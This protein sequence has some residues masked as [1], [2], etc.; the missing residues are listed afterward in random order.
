MNKKPLLFLGL[1]FA[2]IVLLAAGCT[3]TTPG[4]RQAG[5]HQSEVV[6]RPSRA[7]IENRILQELEDLGENELAAIERGQ[8]QPATSDF[9]ITINE[10]V[11][12][13]ID[14]YQTKM[15]ARFTR[16]LNRSGRYYTMMRDILKEYGLPQ[17]LFYIALIESGFTN[18]AT[19][20][21]GAGGPWQ[22]MP[23]TARRFGLRVDN[24]VDERRDP[25]K[26]THAAA[27]YLK[28]L[29]GEF[30]SWYLAAAAYN[31][32]ENK[33]RKALSMYGVNDF[34]SI[35]QS[36]QSYL[37]EETKQYVPRMIAAAIIAKEP[38][39]YGFTEVAYEPPFA[40]D[41]MTIH[42][43]TSLAAI[44]KAADISTSDL[45]DLNPELKR[46]ASPPGGM[47][48]LRIPDGSYAK[49]TQSYAS[50]T[51]AQRTASVSA[52][53]AS[54]YQVRRG[55]TLASVARRYNCSVAQLCSAN[56]RINRNTSLRAGQVL[57]LPD[58]AARG[59]VQVASSG[60]GADASYKVRRGDTLAAI[61]RNYNCTTSQLYALNPSLNNK[62]NVRVGQSL[63]V[64]GASPA[65]S[66]AL[67]RG[68]SRSAAAS[69]VAT[70]KY[71]VRGGD[72]LVA[73]AQRHNCAISQLYA[74]NPSLDD[75]PNIREGQT[76]KV[77]ENVI[78]P[79]VLASAQG[80]SAAASAGGREGSAVASYT[81]RRGDTLSAIAQRYDCDA[82]QLYALNPSLNN[83]PNVRAGQSLRVPGG[84]SVA[85]SAAA[86]N[87]GSRPVLIGGNTRTITHKVQSGD[88]I[89]SL[90]RNY[91]M[92]AQEVSRQLG[93]EGLYAGEKLT[94][95]VPAS[96]AEARASQ[97]S[98]AASAEA[99]KYYVVQSGDT[100]WGLSSRFNVSVN[101][102]KR[103]NNLR[104][105]NLSVGTK[106][107]LK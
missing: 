2:A 46:A 59:D 26:A 71:T 73:I 68:E 78:P 55:D 31:A 103:I 84:G 107:Q 53:A 57:N 67:A 12:Y 58:G 34:W 88:T 4:G 37:A 3:T 54:T 69:Q 44:A 75:K 9:P 1:A 90:A 27:Q 35:S 80:R 98:R 77:P 41:E 74:L 36:D 60:R 29:Y 76:L 85:S 94:L 81:V 33:I 30:G 18:S 96:Q 17:D 10:R 70:T 65:A 89:H 19:S 72:T 7:E 79:A 5:S 92:S 102:I 93:R 100:L 51:P 22:F 11:E 8:T 83:K 50:L 82:S 47:Y 42:P 63:R 49:M 91:N 52:P 101:D 40:Y 32:G 39:K 62:P 23:A 25:V 20:H 106:L 24:W 97:P 43:T 56:P 13:F 105:N 21:A 99:S 6:V 66:P 14:Y 38:A 104:N 61:A 64:P 86:G 95:S 16:Y 48:T 87:T 28:F 45:A 15:P